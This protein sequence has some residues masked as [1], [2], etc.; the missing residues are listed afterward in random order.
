[1][2]DWLNQFGPSEPRKAVTETPDWL[3]DLE[4][5]DE[6]SPG[7]DEWFAPD[8]SEPGDGTTRRG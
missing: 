5:P 4:K 6:R 7:K 8:E 2:D 1:M 3:T